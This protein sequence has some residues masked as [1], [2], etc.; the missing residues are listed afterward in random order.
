LNDNIEFDLVVLVARGSVSLQSVTSTAWYTRARR[1]NDPLR[2]GV[3]GVGLRMLGV[4]LGD[5]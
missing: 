1:L 5:R 3:L 2:D 4:G